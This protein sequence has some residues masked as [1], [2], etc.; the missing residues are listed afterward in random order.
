MRQSRL[1]NAH[2]LAVQSTRIPDR[3]LRAL[4]FVQEVIPMRAILTII[5][6]LGLAGSAWA[7][8]VA[9]DDRPTLFVAKQPPTR[10]EIEQRD[11][12]HKYVHGLL[13]VHEERYANALKA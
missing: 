1:G 10:R 9:I 3:P 7:Q 2:P 6:L 8:N 4:F 11:S 13:L 5:L 12:L